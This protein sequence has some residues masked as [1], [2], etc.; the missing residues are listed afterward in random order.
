VRKKAKEAL[1]DERLPGNEHVE[2]EKL[3]GG[4][5]GIQE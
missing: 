2:E 3:D 5:G 1:G 4:W